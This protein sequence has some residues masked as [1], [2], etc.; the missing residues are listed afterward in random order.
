MENK[1]DKLFRAKLEQHSIAPSANAWE[2][3]AAG[4]P[5]KNNTWALSWRIAAAVALLAVVS[6]LAYDFTKEEKVEITKDN[7]IETPRQEVVTKDKEVV[8]KPM[9][10]K[11]TPAPVQRMVA[12]RASKTTTTPQVITNT[13]E[14]ETLKE[15][16]QPVQEVTIA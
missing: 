4:F 9:M 6:W 1:L 13:N 14:N 10:E 16:I 7:T 3:V 8:E 12:D 11:K 5:K 2:K 15:E